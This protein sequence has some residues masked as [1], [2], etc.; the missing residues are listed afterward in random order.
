M[1][2]MTELQTVKEALER[3]CDN[4]AFILNNVVIPSDFYYEKFK[5]ELEA[6]RKAFAEL[7]SYIKARDNEELWASLAAITHTGDKVSMVK[8]TKQALENTKDIK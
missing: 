3:Q 2:V 8:T 6:D 4:M 5:T 7:N 1:G